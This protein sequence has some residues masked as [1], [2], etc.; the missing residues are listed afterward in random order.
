MLVT[1]Y[2]RRD[3]RQLHTKMKYKVVFYLPEH[4]LWFLY[5]SKSIHLEPETIIHRCSS[6]ASYDAL[7]ESDFLLWWQGPPPKKSYFLWLSI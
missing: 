6:A 5:S 1:C 4:T 3:A 7:V 2:N